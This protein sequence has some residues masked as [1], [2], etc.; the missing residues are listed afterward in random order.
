MIDDEFKVAKIIPF[1][2]FHK[3]LRSNF[4]ITKRQ[5]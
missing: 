5:Y 3:Y 1:L 4:V 2:F